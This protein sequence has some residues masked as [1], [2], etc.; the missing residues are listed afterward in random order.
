M[1]DNLCLFSPPLGMQV[2][3]WAGKSKD[4]MIRLSVLYPAL[5]GSDSA[6][7]A[8]IV[9]GSRLTLLISLHGQQ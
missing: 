1:I 5:S 3:R 9:L 7:C 6:I 4:Q 8:L 2:H